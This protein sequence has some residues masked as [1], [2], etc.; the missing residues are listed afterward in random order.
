M[1]QDLPRP[2]ALRPF[3]P[4]ADAPALR[5]RISG[6]TDLMTW[7]GA[8]FR[9]PLEDAQLTAYAAEPGRRV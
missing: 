5:S 2:L 9:R 8:H 6:P 4:A 1:R 7:A 3:H